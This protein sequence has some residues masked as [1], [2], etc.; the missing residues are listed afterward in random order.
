MARTVPSF[1]SWM[2][3]NAARLKERL[4]LGAG[5]DEDAFQDAY[6]TLAESSRGVDSP[7]YEHSFLR[8]YRSLSRRNFRETF[9]TCHPDELFFRLLAAEQEDEDE[10]PDAEA[11]LSEGTETFARQVRKHIRDAFPRPQ[12]AAFEMRLAGY[13]CRDISDVLGIGSSAINSATE[14]IIAQTRL[15]FSNSNRQ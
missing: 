12:A 8:A 4:S 5:F 1:N 2:S 9:R 3:L 14:H 10:Q 11:S 15:R 13:S 7:D 6:L